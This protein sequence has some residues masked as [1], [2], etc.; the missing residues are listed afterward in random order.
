MRLHVVLGAV[1]K[2]RHPG[3]GRE[4]VGQ[5]LTLDDMGG[6]WKFIEKAH[7]ILKELFEKQH[8]KYYELLQ[9]KEALEEEFKIEEQK[10]QN[11]SRICDACGNCRKTFQ[12][13]S[14]IKRHIRTIYSKEFWYLFFQIW[15]LVIV[16]N[17]CLIFLF[18]EEY[19][20]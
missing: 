8:T 7:S 10:L 4:G 16:V 1:H 12:S 14:D 11:Q 5:M 6:N 18:F 17:F 9:S 19:Q 13:S 15:I 3:R 20:L 2:L